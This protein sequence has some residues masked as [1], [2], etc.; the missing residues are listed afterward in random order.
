MSELLDYLPPALQAAVSIAL[1]LLM[2]ATGWFGHRAG[3]KAESPQKA[4]LEGM[5]G[6][7]STKPLD[8]LS[9]HTAELVAISKDMRASLLKIETHADA[10]ALEAE[11]QRR[12][13]QRQQPP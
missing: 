6:I 7:F 5:S 10:L 11:V 3:R 1:M 2:L 13:K 4:A 12:V 8:D 9:K